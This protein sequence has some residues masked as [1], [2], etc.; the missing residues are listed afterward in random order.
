MRL[1]NCPRGSHYIIW[2]WH[3]TRSRG[4][5]PCH[6]MKFN[7]NSFEII[8]K[9]L[10]HLYSCEYNLE[11]FCTRVIKPSSDDFLTRIITVVWPCCIFYV[12]W[13]ILIVC[14]MLTW[15]APNIACPYK[16]DK[17]THNVWYNSDMPRYYQPIHTFTSFWKKTGPSVV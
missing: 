15:Y 16:H 8:K 2:Q 6:I 12:K 7:C 9:K 11:M 4:S 14:H 3:T 13:I 1:P 5:F 17:W 10:S